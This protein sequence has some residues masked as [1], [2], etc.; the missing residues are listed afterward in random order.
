MKTRA[1]F[2][3]RW[4]DNKTLK[5]NII[6]L[7]KMDFI[8]YAKPEVTGFFCRKQ[9]EEMQEYDLFRKDML[10]AFEL[11][12]DK[13]AELQNKRV[14]SLEDVYLSFR[15]ALKTAGH[16][17][18]GLKYPQGQLV[19][20]ISYIVEKMDQVVPALAADEEL[21]SKLSWENIKALRSS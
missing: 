14:H 8:Q 1:E 5:E 7:F 18:Q 20:M 16:L 17:P 13:N 12:D 4:D 3:S 9:H 11:I 10:A 19:K 15:F 21:Q 2:D 6:N